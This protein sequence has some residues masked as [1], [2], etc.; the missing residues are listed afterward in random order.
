[1][2]RIFVVGYMHSGTTLVRDIL[3][4]HRD[5]YMTPTETKFFMHLGLVRRAW[6][7]LDAP[8]TADAFRRF[9]EDLLDRGFPTYV[10]PSKGRAEQTGLG[11]AATA[12]SSVSRYGAALRDVLDARAASAAGWV[13]K[14][15]THVYHVDQIRSAIPDAMF[16]EVIRD[17]RDVLASKK[18]RKETVGEGRYGRPED[19]ELRGLLRAYDPVLDALSWRSA[20][21]AGSAGRGAA[22]DRWLRVRYEDLVADPP[23]VAASICAFLGIGF[24]EELLDVHRGVPAEADEFT[25]ETTGVV[26]SSQG[27]WPRVLT[28]AEVAAIQR[29]CRT[30]MAALGYAPAATR[31]SWPAAYLRLGAR[32]APGLARRAASRLRLGGP[33]YLADV[34]RGYARRARQF[35]GRPPR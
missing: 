21:A 29:L 2:K 13:E 11:R 4:N 34:I 22:P 3:G 5:L 35:A 30:E 10:R 17:P 7:D 6:G 28:D 12:P 16:V 26:T 14:T 20:I 27:R 1:M 18:T 31:A 32:T 15:P 33:A 9:C 8:G 25:R 24:V 23:D 19:Q